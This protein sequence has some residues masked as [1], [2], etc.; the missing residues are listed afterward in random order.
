MII[1]LTTKTSY[2]LSVQGNF[3]DF[4]NNVSR[5]IREG[6]RD[7]ELCNILK[8]LKKKAVLEKKV[9]TIKSK[10]EAY[11]KEKT[12]QARSNTRKKAQKVNQKPNQTVVKAQN[13]Q[14][15]NEGERSFQRMYVRLIEDAASFH[16]NMDMMVAYSAH[17]INMFMHMATV[18]PTQQ[19][20]AAQK[21]EFDSGYC[22]QY[23]RSQGRHPNANLYRKLGDFSTN[24]RLPLNMAFYKILKDIDPDGFSVISQ[25]NPKTGE[26][27]KGKNPNSYAN[28]AIAHAGLRT[29]NIALLMKG[30]KLAGGKG[31]GDPTT[32]LNKLRK[33][34]P[35][36]RNSFKKEI[37][38]ATTF[39]SYHKRFSELTV[40]AA[41]TPIGNRMM[42]Y[43]FERIRSL[44][45]K[46]N[47]AKYKYISVKKTQKNTTCLFIRFYPEYEGSSA[48]IKEGVTNSL[49]SIFSGI[50]QYKLKQKNLCLRAERR[51]S[52]GFLRPTLTDAGILTMR[53]SLGLEPSVFDDVVMETLVDLE[54]VLSTY[55]FQQQHNTLVKQV[56][57]IKNK[58]TEKKGQYAFIQ[59]A[60]SSDRK[61]LNTFN[62]AYA[63][64]S[65]YGQTSSILSAVKMFLTDYILQE[66][67]L[68]LPD[69]KTESSLIKSQPKEVM[70]LLQNCISYA[71]EMALD[72]SFDP[73]NM[74]FQHSFLHAYQKLFKN[75]DESITLLNNADSLCADEIFYRA[76][77]YIEN[78]IEYCLL[79]NAF[80]Y[81]N[82][83]EES[84][85]YDPVEIL[86]ERETRYCCRHLGI[87]PKQLNL[88]FTDSGQQA[89]NL[90]MLSYGHIYK[91][92]E[93]DKACVQLLGTTYFE[94]SSFFD[95]IK[96]DNVPTK[97][98]NND[99]TKVLVL[100][101][102]Q[103]DSLKIKDY[104]NLAVCLIDLTHFPDVN[105][106]ILKEKVRL[107]LGKNVTCVLSA[108]L[109]KH[110][111]LGQDK[112]QS[113]R[114]F[115]ISP[116]N[117]ESQP[118]L[119]TL[120]EFQSVS[121]E[122]MNPY[123]ASALNMFAQIS[124]VK[125]P[126]PLSS[127]KEHSL[128]SNRKEQTTQVPIK[129]KNL[130]KSRL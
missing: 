68:D 122:A 36:S 38:S 105:N 67:E 112:Y 48:A 85:V 65:K 14:W 29:N 82:K 20:A 21:R 116:D 92:S 71:K 7:I 107:L 87:N 114:F 80:D 106:P 45:A 95:D 86:R 13:P 10:I 75:V 128:F 63:Y 27:K 41:M 62:Q 90:P 12:K 30:L 99:K 130:N 35:P 119:E 121:D 118:S 40:D 98:D 101:I 72:L 8:Q 79:L 15:Q 125:T 60:V 56:L 57:A 43:R 9:E 59:S 23:G 81:P 11:F 109:L 110:E 77:R 102:S 89:I 5:M 97:T 113:G 33:V 94:I 70:C 78:M 25:F 39:Q 44:E 55:N 123:L 126:T 6:K 53:L 19:H 46:I 47:A 88:F 73:N 16:G 31:S 51:Q 3:N 84:P 100:D 49:I 4:R 76:T 28:L 26:P 117:E 83:L 124:N 17:V 91:N 111:Q 18:T 96:K 2:D 1:Q 93:N 42:S 115:L 74:A 103:I 37:N 54:K 69:S 64:I 127:L 34:L 24:N 104:P 50:L 120:D 61:T 108:S 22:L 32:L 129:K 66:K 58:D 52:F